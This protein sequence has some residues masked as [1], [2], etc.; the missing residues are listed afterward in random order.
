MSDDVTLHVMFGAYESIADV[1]NSSSEDDFYCLIAHT[2][3]GD[4]C[5]D[6]V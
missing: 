3:H 1:S 4:T 6:T 5:P 2:V